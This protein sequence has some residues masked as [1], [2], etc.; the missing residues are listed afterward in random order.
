MTTQLTASHPSR[1]VTAVLWGIQILLAAAFV[2][3]GG[4]KLAGVPQMVAVFDQIGVGQWFRYVTGAIEIAA[5]VGLLMPRWTA[6]AAALLA[7]TMTCATLVHLTKIGGSPLPAL[8]L[9]ALSAF[10]AYR[11]WPARPASAR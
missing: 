1:A 8:V 7:V 5:A 11:R 4:A 2:A 9:G 6:Y 10:V 3:A